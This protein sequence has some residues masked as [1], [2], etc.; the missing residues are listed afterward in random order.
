MWSTGVFV[1]LLRRPLPNLLD[2]HDQFVAIARDP[3]TLG[4]VLQIRPTLE[5]QTAQVETLR[6]G[7]RELRRAGKRVVAFSSHYTRSSYYLAA[8]ADEVLIQPGGFID[9]LATRRSYVF[10]A[11]ALERVGL[12]ADVIAISPF[13]T[14][15]DTLS[16]RQL[17]TE[18]REMANWLLDSAT[19]EFARAIAQGRIIREAEAHALIDATP[20][21]DERALELGVVDAIVS[22]EALA[23]HVGSTRLATFDVARSLLR[24]ARPAFPAR[25]E[26]ALIPIEGLIVDGESR[27][28]PVPLPLPLLGDARSGDLTVVQAIR[29]AQRDS[30]IGA[31]VVYVDSPGGSPFASEAIHAAITLLNVE[32][33]V[34]VAMGSVAASGGYYVAAPGYRVFAQPGTLTGSIGVVST[35]IVA[36]GLLD[37]LALRRETLHRGRH[38]L[39]PSAERPYT[40]EERAL[41]SAQIRRSYQLFVERVA[42]GRHMSTDAVEAVRRRAVRGGVGTRRAARPPTASCAASAAASSGRGA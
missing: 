7:L 26:V 36:R 35:K 22:P 9:V 20:C 39:L 6:D 18:A 19:T 1:R 34:V 17:S 15:M 11:D 31:V 28:T 8:A 4:V 25:R 37:R 3:R 5:L 21:T 12:E 13:K 23:T 27:R 14:A 38:A 40:A 42:T 2:V 41:V 24:T 29:R 16:A 10:L 32:K 30:R 33:P